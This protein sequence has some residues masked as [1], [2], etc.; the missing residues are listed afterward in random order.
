MRATCSCE[1]D[2]DTST[3]IP[4]VLLSQ[5]GTLAIAYACRKFG[6]EPDGSWLAG[7]AAAAAG[8]SNHQQLQQ[9]QLISPREAAAV[10]KASA[11][12]TAGEDLRLL[13]PV[14]PAKPGY[15]WKPLKGEAAAAAVAGHVT[16]HGSDNILGFQVIVDEGFL[17][18]AEGVYTAVVLC[19]LEE[20][21]DKQKHARMSCMKHKLVWLQISLIC[22]KCTALTHLYTL[23]TVSHSCCRSLRALGTCCPPRIRGSA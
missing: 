1:H 18:F 8:S 17:R 13:R 23:C 2:V 7:T 10:A 19:T 4:H 11:S 9:Q 12:A 20:A 6:G 15:Y 5:G 3:A 14:D 21:M 22:G 16:L